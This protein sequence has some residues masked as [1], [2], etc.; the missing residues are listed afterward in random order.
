MENLSQ[1]LCFLTASF[2]PDAPHTSTDACY[3]RRFER[4]V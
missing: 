1:P 3:E 2:V 4:E